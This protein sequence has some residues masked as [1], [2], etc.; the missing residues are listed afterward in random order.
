MNLV[1]IVV[2][3]YRA[4][5]TLGAC[6]QSVVNQSHP[7]WELLLV[8]DGSPDGSG[9]LCDALAMADCRIQVIHQENAG[10]STARNRGM[11]AAKGDWILFLDA[12]DTISPVLL[13]SAL[14][15]AQQHPTEQI[16]WP[17]CEEKDG[18]CA[19][20]CTSGKPYAF[21]ETSTLY[22][23]CRL[24]MPW[25]KLFS[26]QIVEQT[27]SLHFDPALSLG[28]DLIFCLDYLAR[29][30]QQGWQGVFCLEKPMTFYNT[31]PSSVSLS[32]AWHSDFHTLWG[33]LYGRLVSFCN[34][35]NCPKQ[36]ILSIHHSHLCTLAH[37]LNG[38][39]SQTQLSKAEKK[40]FAKEVFLHPDT[41]QV[42]GQ[43]RAAHRYSPLLTAFRLKSLGLVCWL[44]NLRSTNMDLYGKL[45]AIGQKL[46]GTVHL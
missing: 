15:A 3:V 16:V 11:A 33:Y 31:A 13:E 38:L 12:D 1:S 23:D 4:Q 6:V 14:Q 28:E 7:H 22:S 32:Q 20:P 34:E 27:P 18:L 26:R 19:T 45:E 46:W 9:G 44:W 39:A 5:H 36:E 24:S 42:C 37:N 25:N 29:I 21:S 17:Y 8:D 2:P 30:Q 43:L 10:V 40:A 41:Q 35:H